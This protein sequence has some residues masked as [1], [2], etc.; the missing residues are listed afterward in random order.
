MI[1]FDNFAERG[2]LRR[3]RSALN[4]LREE[5][6]RL[7]IASGLGYTVKR[8][9]C[10]TILNIKGT[11]QTTAPTDI[12]IAWGLITAVSDKNYLT[13]EIDAISET[14]WK[15][16]SCMGDYE[17]LYP[18]YIAL[19]QQNFVL[20]SSSLPVLDAAN[21]V[22]EYSVS[23]TDDAGAAVVN[24]VTESLRPSYAVGNAI[25]CISNVGDFTGGPVNAWYDLNIDA[26][27]WTIKAISTQVCVDGVT[28]YSA[29]QRAKT[30]TEWTNE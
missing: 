2:P 6:A 27:H 23:T 9:A 15:P 20:G 26:R 30:N 17:P 5:V 18:S 19:R 13:C 7:R 11:K 4:D 29:V 10:G 1:K 25:L 8:T 12:R 14:V 3:I 22:R 16:Y 24:H 21:S 28:E